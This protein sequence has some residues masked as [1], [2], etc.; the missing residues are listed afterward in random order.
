VEFDDQHYFSPSERNTV[1]NKSESEKNIFFSNL[2]CSERFFQTFNN[3][4]E[5][6]D[7]NNTLFKNRLGN[8]YSN[9]KNKF[10]KIYFMNDTTTSFGKKRKNN[11]YF[12]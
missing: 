2:N 10:K 11:D 4:Y 1:G 3:F 7:D 9:I 6:K 5:I 8:S 12:K